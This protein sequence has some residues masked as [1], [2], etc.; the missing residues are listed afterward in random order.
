[1]DVPAISSETEFLRGMARR[2]VWDQSEAEALAMPDRIIRRV[3]DLGVFDDA[4]ALEPTLGR[5]RLIQVLR[6]APP[7]AMRPRSW[8]F[9]HYRLGLA[10][11]RRDPPPMPV[12]SFD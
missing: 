9:W 2:Y 10:D 7:G 1:M 5:A 12:R 6:A 4:L 3:M 11:V 8:W